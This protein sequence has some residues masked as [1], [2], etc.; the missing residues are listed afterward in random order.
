MSMLNIHSSHYGILGSSKYIHKLNHHNHFWSAAC[1]LQ[2][3]S[4][5][6]IHIAEP[7]LPALCLSTQVPRL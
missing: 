6:Y 5:T 7:M 4:T 2:M 3:I 1:A